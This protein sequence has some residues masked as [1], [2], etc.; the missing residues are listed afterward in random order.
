VKITASGPAGRTLRRDIGPIGLLFTSVGSIIGSGWLF[1]ALRATAFAGP[2]AILSWVIGGG[3]MVLLALIHAELGG[4]YPV[5]GGSAR[6]PQYAFGTMIGFVSGWFAFLGTVATAPIEAEAA[7]QYASNYMKGLTTLAG[8]G[9]PV[10]T[11]MGFVVATCLMLVFSAINV[12]GVRWLSEINNAAVW[13]KIAIPVLTVIVL[14]AT[15]FHLG[16]FTA[17][18][19]FLP[20]GWKGV[21]VAMAGGGVIFSFLG[22]EQAI[23]LGAES[24]NP[25]RNIP[26]AVIGSMILG[27]LLYVALQVTFIAALDPAVLGSKGWNLAFTG[28][29]ATYGPFAGLTVALGLGWLAFLIYADA[30][31][32]PGGTGLLYVGTSSRLLFALAR[33]GYVPGLFAQLSARCVPF[34][35]IAFSFLCGVLL[36]LPFPGWYKLVGFVSSATVIA[37]AM[38][39]LALG[40]LR[41]QEPDRERPFRLPCASALAPL[42][43]IV[44]NELILFSSWAVVQKLVVAIAIGFVLLAISSKTR[45]AE[46]RPSFDWAS[47]RW[48]WPYLAGVALISYLGSFDITAKDSAPRGVLPFGWDIL[49]MAIFSTAIYFLAVGARLSDERARQY[50]G[51]PVA[52]T[53]AALWDAPAQPSTAHAC[54]VEGTMGRS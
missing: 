43:F 33:D 18:G 34:H 31:I 4:M 52:E 30:V 16:N 9:T 5:A 2:A 26:L 42:G 40:A 37:Y 36:F 45:S 46:K 7:L 24:R 38:A 21:F 17:G 49:T 44:A 47:A 20:F 25:Q 11:G 12:M 8:D 39:P 53:E 29:G 1:G 48:L 22:F 27:V 32:S 10:L 50:I 13:W 14:L 28:T 35:A 23:Q 51:D 19:G 54:T 15:S 3:A 41:R 6:F